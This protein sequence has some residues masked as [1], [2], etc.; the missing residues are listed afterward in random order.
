VKSSTP[1]ALVLWG[2]I[3]DEAGKVEALDH[4]VEKK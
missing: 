3:A 4:Y 1:G 2:K